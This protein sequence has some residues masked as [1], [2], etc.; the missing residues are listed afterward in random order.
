MLM[1]M[2][3]L[4]SWFRL[5]SGHPGRRFHD[6]YRYRQMQRGYKLTFAKA[7]TLLSSLAVIAIGIVL[8]PLPG[9]GTGI[10]ALGLA[11]LGSE[12]EPVA[13]ALDWMELKVRPIIMPLK[14]K[15]DSI[16]PMT[17]LSLSL[18]AGMIGIILTYTAYTLFLR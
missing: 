8:M 15:W 5:A 16:K 3:V 18:V 12:F 6:F 11:L 9:P 2:R 4:T 17:R 14:K 10:V 7:V 1:L 13:R